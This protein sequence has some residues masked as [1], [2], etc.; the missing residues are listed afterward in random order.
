M[1]DAILKLSVRARWAILFLTLAAAAIGVWQS[2]LLP[3]DVTPDITNKQV[4]INTPAQPA[5]ISVTGPL[6]SPYIRSPRSVVA[7]GLFPPRPRT[8]PV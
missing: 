5:A 2:L 3:I 6:V 7:G 1:I 4:Q 8:E